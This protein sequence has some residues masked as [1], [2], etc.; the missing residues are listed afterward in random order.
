MVV[1][2]NTI[3]VMVFILSRSLLF[4]AAINMLLFTR[5]CM[6]AVL[7]N[8][9]RRRQSASCSPAI[10][11]LVCMSTIAPITMQVSV[12]SILLRRIWLRIGLVRCASSAGLC[13]KFASVGS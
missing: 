10:R 11:S 5:L 4:S 3:D 9:M 13:T 2:K 12:V 6:L 1:L 7:C 8:V